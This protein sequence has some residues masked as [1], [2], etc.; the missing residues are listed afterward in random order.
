[1]ARFPR[2]FRKQ[3]L[4]EV[5]PARMA[6]EISRRD[7]AAE[8][9]IGWVQLGVV[10]FFAL[11]YWIAPRAEGASGFNF[12]PW[13]LA[14]YCLFTFWRLVQSYRRE[15]PNWVLNL[16]IIVDILLLV[17][18]IFSFHIQYDQPPAFY[19]KAPT[20]MYMFLFIALRA[21][22][23]DP[24]FVLTAGGVAA[25]GWSGLVAYAVLT[26][27][28][29]MVVTRN[30]VHYLTSNALLVGAE[31]DKLIIIL[32]VTLLLAFGL[33]RARGIFFEGSAIIWRRAN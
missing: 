15:M 31:L 23:L 25:L 26:D 32:A 6:E 16:S 7:V 18:I 13:A 21:L 10:V 14:V 12:I 30:Y 4:S 11:L 27:P 29:G 22:R 17:G 33:A 5:I 24:R 19:L 2:L 8:R 9:L 1:M 3:A 28:D 20:V